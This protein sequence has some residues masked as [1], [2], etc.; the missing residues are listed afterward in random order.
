L[1]N[2]Q[3]EIIFGYTR[4]EM[5]GKEIEM[6]IPSRFNHIH[7]KHRGEFLINPK[8]RLIDHSKE[9]FGLN[10]SGVEFPVE[11]SLSHLQTDEG[12][13][14]SAAVRDITEQKK[15]STELSEAKCNAE[16]ATKIAEEAVKSKQQFLSNMSH[17]IRTPMNAI[18]GFTKVVLKTDLS[19][20]QK[21]YLSA[22]QQSGNT[23]IVLIDD[24]LD[25]AKVNAGKMT[26]ESKPFRLKSS[27]SSMIHLFE[28]KVQEKN[29][30]LENKYDERIPDFIVGDSVR[31]NQ[32][33]LNLIS[34][35][36]KFTSEGKITLDVKLIEEN[37]TTLGIEFKVIDTGIGIPPHKLATIFENFQQA[38]T[39][40]SRF[41]GGTGLGLA[42]VKQLVECQ[43]GSIN[44]VSEVSQGST[45]SFLLNFKKTNITIDEESEIIVV[46]TE[47]KHLKILVVE[48]IALNQLLMKTILDDFGFEIDI[49]ENGK[50]AIEKIQQIYYDIVLMDLQMPVMNGFEATKYIRE[51]LKLELPIIALTADVTTVDLEKCKAVGMNDYIAKPVDERLLYS[52]IINQIKR[53]TA[54]LESDRTSLVEK[55]K[56]VDLTFL[57]KRTKSNSKLMEEMIALYLKQTPPIVTAMIDGLTKKDWTLLG[58]SIHKISPSFKIMGIDDTYKKMLEKVEK[59]IVDR[60]FDGIDNLVHLIEKVCINSCEELK[61]EILKYK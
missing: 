61:I 25:L 33:I 48:D 16:K 58:A 37:D 32:M 7:H 44:V 28:T 54:V 15:I 49:A 60:D 35:A 41:Y 20:K 29:L 38:Y 55:M 53:V 11:V 27:I 5:I 56:Y 42:I 18:I 9:L 59:K 24:I 51:T 19:V 14:I 46:D 43:G 2:S 22:I 39:S 31:L 1:V 6:L 36:V 52:K 47:I 17:E 3:T 12:I 4:E 40:T 50:I 21:E 13:L 34:N 45:F 26:F 23:L 57:L 30:I 10:K 8:P